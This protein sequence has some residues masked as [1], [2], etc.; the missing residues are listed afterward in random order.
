M[1]L[2]FPTL[3][4]TTTEYDYITIKYDMNWYDIDDCS[5][6]HILSSMN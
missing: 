1:F 4:D 2:M 5:F 6:F 3:T